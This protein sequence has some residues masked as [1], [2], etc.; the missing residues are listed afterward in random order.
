MMGPKS[1]MGPG[2]YAA[3]NST[4]KPSALKRKGCRNF[5]RKYELYLQNKIY[6]LNSK[7]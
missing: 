7:T 6:S 5:Q 4:G 1:A 3:F 2:N